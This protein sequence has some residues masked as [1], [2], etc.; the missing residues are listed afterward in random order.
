M[1]QSCCIALSLND[2]L[3]SSKYPAGKLNLISG[4]GSPFSSAR[5]IYS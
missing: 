1:H 2:R 3:Y 4:I 5:Q